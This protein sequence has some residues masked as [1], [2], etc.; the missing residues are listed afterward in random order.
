MKTK[1]SFSL[2]FLLIFSGVPLLL[3]SHGNVPE[4]SLLKTALSAIT[5]LAFWFMMGQMYLAQPNTF[6][7]KA[8]NM[9]KLVKL[10]KIIG[11]TCCLIVLFHPIYLVFPR[12]YEGGISPLDSLMII[13]TS[14]SSNGVVLGMLSWGLML[15]L[16][17]T[18]LLRKSLPLPYKSWKKLHGVISALFIALAS[19]HVIE[20][21]RHSNLLTSIIL[22][23]LLGGGIFLLLKHYFQPV[24]TISANKRG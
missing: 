24:L 4:R 3:L 16:A 1:Q 10:H 8:L 13:F 18:S 14:F 22:L 21:G 15:L 19:W 9:R 11:Y 23:I 12:L 7:V 20:L 17:I 6:A 2:Y 5:I